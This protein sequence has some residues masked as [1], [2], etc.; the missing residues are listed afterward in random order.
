MHVLITGAAGFVGRALAQR[1]QQAPAVGGRA[2]TRLSLLDLAL[3]A[4]EP[5]RADPAPEVQAWPCDLADPAA[6][7]AL[8]A[9]LAAAPVDVVFH[10]ASIPGGLAEQQVA[11]ARRVN[12]DATAVLLE[13]AQAQV[14]AGG[15]VPVFVF[16]SSIAV[17]GALPA[18]VDDHTPLQPV[19]SYGMHKVVGELLVADF[20]RRGAVCGRSLRLPGVLAR[21]PAPTGQLSAFLSDLPRELA[22]GRPC[23]CPTSPQARTWASSLPCVLAQLLHA[24]S[25][26]AAAWPAGRALTPPTLHFSLG[27]M[28]DAVAQVH[29]V[30]AQALVR[31]AP[32]A[33]TE[34]LFGRFPPLRTPAA[35]AAGFVHDGDLPTLLR[36]A[37]AP[38]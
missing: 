1:L 20:T 15:P 32:D 38:A 33:R 24:A 23:V 26:P 13:A 30:P 5:V 35:E 31:W 37:L 34:A 9:R 3:T 4:P 29:G 18:A 7:Q 21:P 12:I 16:A 2:V 17:F 14:Q 28:V 6:Q 10:L 11:L 8:A 19:L 22:A 27:E 36:R 25:T